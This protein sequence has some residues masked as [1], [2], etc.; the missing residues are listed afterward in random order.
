MDAPVL[1]RQGREDRKE[2]PLKIFASL[3]FFAVNFLRASVVGLV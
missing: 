3:A 1:N 2:K